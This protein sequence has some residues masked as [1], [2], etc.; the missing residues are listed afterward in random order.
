MIAMAVQTAARIR[1]GRNWG[2][3]WLFAPVDGAAIAYFRIAFGL[4]MLWEVYQFSI[5][6]WI[7]EYF[8]ENEFLFTYPGFGWVHPWPEF[9]L[10]LHFAALGIAAFCL[11]VGFLYRIAAIFFLLGFLYIFLLDQARYLNHFY[12]IVLISFLLVFVPCHRIWSVDAGIGEFLACR[13]RR[14]SSLRRWFFPSPALP[15]PTPHV[16]AWTQLLL[17]TQIG[18]VYVYGGIAKLDADWL[19]GYAVRRMFLSDAG[20]LQFV[21]A[22]VGDQCVALVF[23]YA[24]LLID[25]LV[26]PALVWRRTRL[27]AAMIAIAFHLTNARYLNIGVFPWLMIAAT[28]LFFESSWLRKTWRQVTCDGVR[29]V[30]GSSLEIGEVIVPQAAGLGLNRVTVVALVGV[31][32]ILQLLIPLRHFAYPGLVHWN[33]DGHQFSWHMKLRGKDTAI[34][35]IVVSRSTGTRVDVYPRRY[36]ADYQV[37]RMSMSP[38]MILQ[39][40][41]FIRDRFEDGGQQDVAVYAD[42]FAALNGRPMQRFV[43]PAVDLA[44]EEYRWFSPTRLVVPLDGA[45]KDKGPT[46]RR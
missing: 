21:R 20:N 7:S 26:V 42:S 8:V 44:Q 16:F 29:K 14:E 46:A 33:E 4:L 25:L 30:P 37:Y 24:G 5:N 34:K 3:S 28:P 11:A 35:F 40:A 9:W 41:H 36:L 17:A 23:A 12:L 1:G 31:Y 45:G 39:F 10:K 13:C 22:L 2:P 18:I 27:P 43:D 32:L 15:L 19:S 38:S 6:D